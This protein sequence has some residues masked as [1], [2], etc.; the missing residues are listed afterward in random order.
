AFSSGYF[1]VKFGVN[2]ESVESQRGY[3]KEDSAFQALLDYAER[4]D[5][6]QDEHFQYIESQVNLESM[7]DWCVYEA[8]CANTDLS[9]NARYLR[10]TEYDGNRW[11]YALFDLD[12]GFS[13]PASFDYILA[14]GWHGVLLRE[15]KGNARFQEMFLERMAYQ[16][17]NHL[18]QEAVLARYDYLI[19]QIEDEMPREIARWHTKR[20]LNWEGHQKKLLDNLHMDREQQLKEAAAEMFRL[21]LAKVESYF[22]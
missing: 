8:Y 4:H 15:L 16:L 2:K 6:R 12:C 1:S 14:D 9:V 11:H 18:T 19:G 22:A 21:P 10:S 13:Y 20:T 7:I 17:Q 5:L 3:I